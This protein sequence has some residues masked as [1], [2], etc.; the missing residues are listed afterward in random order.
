LHN[1]RLYLID[2]GLAIRPYNSQDLTLPEPPTNKTSNHNASYIVRRR[3]RSPSSDLFGA[4]LV[5]VD[6]MDSRLAYTNSQGK[7]VCSD[8]F[9]EFIG[10]LL[11]P[12]SG[13]QT[14]TAALAALC[15]IKLS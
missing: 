11:K 15:K 10:K 3:D 9:S 7:P 5:A 2:F 8:D 6:L 4:G 1:K 14:T 12:E 13:Y